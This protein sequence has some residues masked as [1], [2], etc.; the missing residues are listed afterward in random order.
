MN[1]F[2][3]FFKR[4]EPDSLDLLYVTLHHSAHTPEKQT[5]ILDFLSLIIQFNLNFFKK[6]ILI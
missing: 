6:K 1:D 2:L 3:L 5:F 4:E